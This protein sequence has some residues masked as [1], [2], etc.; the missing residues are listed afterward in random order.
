[1]KSL[2]SKISILL[3]I[4]IIQ[5]CNL[6]NFFVQFNR[7]DIQHSEYITLHQSDIAVAQVLDAWWWGTW[8]WPNPSWAGVC[9][10]SGQAFSW[11]LN[12]TNYDFFCCSAHNECWAY[13][14]GAWWSSGN[15]LELV[16]CTTW[17]L[18]ALY[19]P[20]T[21]NQPILYI[22]KSTQVGGSDYSWTIYNGMTGT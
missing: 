9:T 12:S 15:I 11:R 10:F 1:M 14:T 19:C 7:G 8:W 13:Y 5:Y 20:V 4:I 18:W 17:A 6:G 2:L 16:R 3:T 21:N 22:Q